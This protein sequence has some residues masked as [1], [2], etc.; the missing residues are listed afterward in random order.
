MCLP[1]HPHSYFRLRFSITVVLQITSHKQPKADTQAENSCRENEPISYLSSMKFHSHWALIWSQ[2]S[3]Q[4]P[5]PN[6]PLQRIT[7]IYTLHPLS[8]ETQ[9]VHSFTNI[10]CPIPK[11]LLT[12]QIFLLLLAIGASSTPLTSPTE[13]E[14]GVVIA[15]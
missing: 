10:N 12:N 4:S 11:M 2:A 7:G 8:Y 5:T 6:L 9:S 15:A 14:S 1:H 3:K 13:S